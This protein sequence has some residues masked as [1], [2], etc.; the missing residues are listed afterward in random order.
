MARYTYHGPVQAIELKKGEDLQEVTLIPGSDPITL[1][2][3]HPAIVSMVDAGLLRLVPAQLPQ[4][5]PA[6]QDKSTGN[7]PTEGEAK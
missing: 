2:K 5:K 4:P 3:D 6:S 7:S 1:P